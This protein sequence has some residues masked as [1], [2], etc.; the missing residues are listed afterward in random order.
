MRF[1]D[2]CEKEVVNISDCCRLG[3]VA[4][5]EFDECNGCIKCLIVPECSHIFGIF[6]PPKELI[7]PWRQVVRIGPD[8]ILV[9]ICKDGKGKH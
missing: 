1:C 9:D 8:I 2:L 5:L 7:I 3:N 4:D 6:S